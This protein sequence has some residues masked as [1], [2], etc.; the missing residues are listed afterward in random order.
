MLV[1]RLLT[2]MAT[3]NNIGMDQ[4]HINNLSLQT[5]C[6][7]D[8]WTR[9]APQHCKISLTIKTDFTRCSATDDLKYSLNYAV[10][11]RDVTNHVN[12]RKNWGHV[13]TLSRSIFNFIGEKYN[14]SIDSMKVTL[15]N[16]DY[17]L[18]TKDIESVI[19]NKDIETLN[20]RNLELFAIIGIF[21]F[22]RL[23]RQKV[24]LDLSIKNKSSNEHPSL[25]TRP[26]I[27]NVVKYVEQSDFKTVEALIESVAKI[28]HQTIETGTSASHVELLDVIVRVTKLSAITDTEGVGVSCL[29]TEKQLKTLKS[30]DI[31]PNDNMQGS[32][33][34]NTI[35]NN[36]NVEI[37]TTNNGNWAKAYLAFGSNIGNRMDYITQALKLLKA[38]PDVKVTGVSSV[39]ESEP[40]YFKEQNPFLNGCIEISTSQKPADLLK[41]CK[42]I[43]YL[44]L[45]RTKDFENGPR[46][47]DLD[48]ILYYDAEG[49]AVQVNTQDLIIPHPRMLERTFVLEPLCELLPPDIT[50]P[51]TIEPLVDHL[52]Q[53]YDQQKPEDILWKVIPLG[54]NRTLSKKDKF[55]K[56]KTAMKHD[57][58]TKTDNRMTVSPTYIMG[59]MNTTPDSFSDGSQNYSDM[60]IQL[61]KV[62]TLCDDVLKHYDNVIID[63]G[64]CSTRPNSKQATEEQEIERTIPLIKAIRASHDIPQDQ[65]LLSIDTYRSRVA[66]RAIEA[67]VDIINDI[68]GGNFD[69]DMFNT[70]AKYPHVAYV[71]SHI[72]GDISTMTKNSSYNTEDEYDPPNSIDY[73]NNNAC[74]PSHK[75]MNLTRIIGY[76]MS[77]RY[78]KALEAGV[79]RWQIILDPGLGFAKNLKENIDIIKQLPLLKNYSVYNNDTSF[80]VNFRNLPLLLGPSRKKFI[81]SITQDENP[82]DRD[83]AT[84]SLVALSIGYGSDI[85]R[86]H[87]AKECAKSAIL[88]DTVYKSI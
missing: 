88:A 2:S 59:I 85:I 14:Q 80:Y 42:K 41:L 74:N 77:E 52:Q 32:L 68:S 3:K 37:K 12:S 4:I 66:E 67:G 60:E 44:E 65:I 29:R 1:K 62:M 58:L 84:G 50:H 75:A 78:S 36:E 49:N 71:L 7:P 76:E 22:E 35:Q 53:L 83:F 9:V 13:H 43:E 34:Y 27:D 6:G 11:C 86:V 18:R 73:I 10:L 38:T 30:I 70:V 20:I 72:R 31:S 25:N 61:K 15:K 82:I 26:I 81:G 28:I 45:K 55:L 8:L 16:E 33:L 51:L 54:N 17:H 46:S 48:I 47:I 64:G 40:M 39:F 56:F 24:S 23:Q 19:E 69:E 63:I 79:H 57:D 21:N 5:I 87:N